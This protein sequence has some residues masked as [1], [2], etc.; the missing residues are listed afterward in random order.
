VPILDNLF[1]PH[2][3]DLQNALGRATQRQAL[4]T[5]NLANVNT[6][7]FKRQD[8]D[9]N[10]ALKEEMDK[11]DLN[12]IASPAPADNGALR[13]DGNSVDLEKEVM[14]ITETELR[15]ETLTAMT[16]DY[17]SRLKT[18]IHEGK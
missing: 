16:T 10:I 15:Y 13:L 3:D 14:N 17:F 18:V 6:P 12:A 5:N 11:P 9:F 7:G 1:G 2:L 8:M 4:L